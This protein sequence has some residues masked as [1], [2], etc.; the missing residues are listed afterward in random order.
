VLEEVGALVV[1][2]EHVDVG[3]DQTRE[4]RHTA[5]IYKG[6]SG[7]PPSLLALAWV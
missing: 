5:A 4:Q 1:V 7:L 6:V 3:I 2:W